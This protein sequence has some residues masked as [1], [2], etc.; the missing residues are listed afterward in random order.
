MGG[1]GLLQL[2]AQTATSIDL[3]S[4]GRAGAVTWDVVL[5]YARVRDELLSLNDGAGNP[6]GT[7][8]AGRTLHSGLEAGFE[9][10]LGQ[11]LLLRQVYNW[12]RFRFDGDPVYGDNQLAG[13]PEHDVRA[14]L[15]Y[16]RE[17]GFYAGPS[18]EWVPAR[19]P[20]DHANTLFADPYT[21]LGFKLGYRAA[22][23]WAGFVEGKNLTD[24]TYAATSVPSGRIWRTGGVSPPVLV[25]TPGGDTATGAD[26]GRSSARYT[27]RAPWAPSSTETA[28][29]PP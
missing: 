20:V 6:L 2:D 11:R 23:G 1:D 16:S 29:S 15:L 13:L 28:W 5:D 17:S 25:R 22:S 14:E 4:R 24:E 27:T 18:V 12:G 7:R 9:I 8:N 19:Y 10:R 3:G 21:L 26:S